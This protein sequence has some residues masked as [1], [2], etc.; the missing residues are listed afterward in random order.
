MRTFRGVNLGV[1]VRT[2]RHEI[3]FLFTLLFFFQLSCEFQFL[4]CS[5]AESTYFEDYYPVV[6]FLKISSSEIF[7]SSFEAILSSKTYVANHFN[8]QTINMKIKQFSLI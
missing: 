3:A 6:L 1:E 2:R 7:M 5:N 4:I 8:F